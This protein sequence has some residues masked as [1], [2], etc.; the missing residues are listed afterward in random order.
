MTSEKPEP[1]DRPDSSVDDAAMIEA[2]RK[3]AEAA[4]RTP[5]EESTQ[6]SPGAGG[7]PTFLPDSFAGYQI[8]QEIHR[9]GQGVVYQAIQKSTSARWRSRS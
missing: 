1:S 9:G 5:A 8:L 4:G 3:E 2:A 6:A 7:A